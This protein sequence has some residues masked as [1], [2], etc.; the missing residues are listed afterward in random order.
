LQTDEASRGV[1]LAP[2]AATGAV[3]IALTMTPPAA[4]P[5]IAPA[6]DAASDDRATA[7]NP[8]RVRLIQIGLGLLLAWL[9]VTIIGLSRVRARR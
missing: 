1:T 9:V 4:A 6:G 8:S 7:T 5:K 2:P 3:V